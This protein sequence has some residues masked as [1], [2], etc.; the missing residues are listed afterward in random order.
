MVYGEGTRERKEQAMGYRSEVGIKIQFADTEGRDRIIAALG[1]RWEVVRGIVEVEGA[2]IRFHTP[3]AKWYVGDGEYPDV[4]VLE[5]LVRLAEGCN[6]LPPD[7]DEYVPS[8]GFFA[9]IGEERNDIE[10]EAWDGDAEG[11]PCGFDLAHV[12]TSIQFDH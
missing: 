10:E 7:D 6:A 12:E 3:F 9:R 5:E 2:T 11:L 1:D 4:Q 8:S